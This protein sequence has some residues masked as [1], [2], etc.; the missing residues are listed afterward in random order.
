MTPPPPQVL[1]GEGPA[2]KEC[3]PAIMYAIVQQHL[4]CAAIFTILPLQASRR[5][6][7][8]SALRPKGL[9]CK[10]HELVGDKSRAFFFF[11]FLGEGIYTGWGL[12][13]SSRC[14]A[15]SHKCQGLGRPQGCERRAEH[16]SAARPQ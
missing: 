3:S 10:Q 5:A 4:D 14:A 9:V 2:P 1:G 15:E 7:V 11:F 6:A 8:H 16:S 12:P 13:M